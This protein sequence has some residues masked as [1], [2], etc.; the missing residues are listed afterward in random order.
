MTSGGRYQKLGEKP[1]GIKV[2][3]CNGLADRGWNFWLENSGFMTFM[4]WIWWHE[5]HFTWIEKKIFHH[6]R[7]MELKCR[8]FIHSPR[9]LA[10]SRPPDLQRASGVAKLVKSAG[11]KKAARKILAGVTALPPGF[12]DTEVSPSRSSWSSFRTDVYGA[13]ATGAQMESR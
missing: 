3:A 9:F 12:E 1:D 11:R 7:A 8:H 4:E 2:D 10:D 5:G 13:G 6:H